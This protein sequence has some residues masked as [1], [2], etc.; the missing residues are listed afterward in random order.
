MKLNVD[1]WQFIAPAT[2]GCTVA[3]DLF[4]D[5]GQHARLEVFPLFYTHA[6]GE[7][8][9]EIIV[10]CEM[11]GEKLNQPLEPKR[12]ISRPPDKGCSWSHVELTPSLIR[13][14]NDMLDAAVE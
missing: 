4:L 7:Q 1:D 3:V 11:P 2:P 9:P 12:W 14:I 13:Q 5:N 8:I 10:Y 6:T